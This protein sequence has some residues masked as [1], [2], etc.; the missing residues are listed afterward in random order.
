VTPARQLRVHGVGGPQAR[1]ILGYLD[2][3]DTYTLPPRWVRLGDGKRRKLPSRPDTRV[4]RPLDDP[5]IEAYEWGGLT[6]GG[7]LKALWVLYLPLTVLNVGGWAGPRADHRG[8]RLATHVACLLGTIA[9]VGWTGYLLLDLVERQWFARITASGSNAPDIVQGL[10]RTVGPW[11][12][13]AVFLG[14]LAGAVW[15]NQRTAKTFEG[16][17]ADPPDPDAES[18]WPENEEVTSRTFFSRLGALKARQRLHTVVAL[19]AAGGVIWLGFVDRGCSHDERTAIGLGLLVVEGVQV[20]ALVVWLAVLAL[21]RQQLT[22]PG[23]A[24]LGSI[25]I[26]AA[27]GGAALALSEYLGRWPT[28]PLDLSPG[29]ELALATTLPMAV[30]ALAVVALAIVATMRVRSPDGFAGYPGKHPPNLIARIVSQVQPLLGG[31]ALIVAGTGAGFAV[32][33]SDPAVTDL[34]SWYDDYVIRTNAVQHV[35][36]LMLALIPVAI[37]VVLRKPRSSAVGTVIG[38]AWDVLTFWPRR[39]HPFGAPPYAERAVP[40]LRL[41]IRT[42]RSSDRALLVLGHSQGSVLAFTAVGAELETADRTR[43]VSLLTFGSPLGSLFGKVFPRYFGPDHRE[44]V[45][46]RIE[47]SGGEWSNLFRSTD[48]ISGPVIPEVD[49]WLPDPRIRQ[50]PTAPDPAG[51]RRPPLERT[52]PYGIGSGHSGYLADPV[53]WAEIDRLSD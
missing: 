2:E 53:T 6:T 21:V 49:R 52:P 18:T 38:N 46:A 27:F 14:V 3:S 19:L 24:A 39:Y 10:V 1:K 9:Y 29:P 44:E 17:L 23:V 25:V 12:V 13:H 15:A 30:A 5:D 36:A 4:V 16:T 26:H 20:V 51:S 32:A 22:Q 43:P 35:G 11:L 50:R 41:L 47:A 42:R 45:R 40:E 8:N 37:Y 34:V 33:Q 48:P 28:G 7:F 31:I